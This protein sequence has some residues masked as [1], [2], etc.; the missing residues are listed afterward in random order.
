MNGIKEYIYAI[1]CAS[2]ICGIFI[3]FSPNKGV[4]SIYITQLVGIVMVTVLICPLRSIDIQKIPELLTDYK[5]DAQMAADIGQRS[6]NS[7]QREIISQQICAYILDKATSLGLDITVEISLD[8]EMGCP[9][10]VRLEGSVSPYAKQRLGNI[11]AQELAV[12]EE[13]LIWIG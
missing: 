8:E 7:K 5:Q 6:A 12:P 1:V 4:T 10:E 3:G 9:W 2:V 13:R 11:I